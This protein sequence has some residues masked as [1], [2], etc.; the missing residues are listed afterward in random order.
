MWC[1]IAKRYRSKYDKKLSSFLAVIKL[2]EIG[3]GH[4]FLAHY[5]LHTAFS[6]KPSKCVP[7]EL[8]LAHFNIPVIYST[9]TLISELC[10]GSTL[11]TSILTLSTRITLMYLKLKPDTYKKYLTLKCSIQAKLCRLVLFSS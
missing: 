8:T 5:R 1:N 9:V 10:S 2:H 6:K 3:K 7:S 4:T 11:N